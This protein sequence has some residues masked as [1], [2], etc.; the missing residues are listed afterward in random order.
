MIDIVGHNLWL[1]N[2]AA[3]IF[4][5]PYRVRWVSPI[6]S[7]VCKHESITIQYRYIQ[8]SYGLE[9]QRG[10]VCLFDTLGNLVSAHYAGAHLAQEA[11]QSRL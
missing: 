6:F 2:W 10:G 8:H 4:C 1:N 7:E 11:N 5:V 9:Y 3:L